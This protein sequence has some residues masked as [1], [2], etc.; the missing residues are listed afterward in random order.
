MAHDAR[1]EIV[2]QKSRFIGWCFPVSTEAE[3][4]EKLDNVRRQHRDASHNCYAYATGGTGG[5]ARFSDDGE[6]GGTAGMP[7]ME[8]VRNKDVTNLLV[9][10]TRYF[11]GV[12][13]GAGGLV[14]AYAKSA[15]AAI[16]AAEPVWMRPC[17]EFSIVCTY[18]RFQVV[19]PLAKSFGEVTDVLYR[20]DVRLTV[21]VP[22]CSAAAFEAAVVDKTDGACHPEKL[23]TC[24]GAFF[25]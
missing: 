18:P 20:E 21:L 23:N 14:R 6:P 19:E 16:E 9:V 11:G 15:S 22:E 25:D 4:L 17:I 7:M 1:I 8:V 12:L 3:A 2:I 24:F 13:L 10:V 5:A